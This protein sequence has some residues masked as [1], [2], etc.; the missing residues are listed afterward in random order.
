MSRR[1]ISQERLNDILD[2]NKNYIGIIERGEG[3]PS[4]EKLC[5]ISNILKI[6]VSDIM[7]VLDNDTEPN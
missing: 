5:Q 2:A 6:K 4:I 3:F 7:K 1:N